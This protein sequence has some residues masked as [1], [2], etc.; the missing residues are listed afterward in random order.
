MGTK[1]RYNFE[2]FIVKSYVAASKF[3]ILFKIRQK[4]RNHFVLRGKVHHK[5][6]LHAHTYTKKFFKLIL[7]NSI[8]WLTAFSERKGLEAIF[9]PF[10]DQSPE[11]KVK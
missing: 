11:Q 6:K 8:F 7:I 1:C 9:W 4:F 3:E 10:S 5:T 2:L